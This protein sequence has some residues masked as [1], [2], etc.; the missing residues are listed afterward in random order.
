MRRGIIPKSSKP[1]P[2]TRI[3]PA[4][5]GVEKFMWSDMLRQ[6]RTGKGLTQHEM[7]ELMGISHPAYNRME[8]GRQ[9]PTISTLARVAE[10]LGLQLTVSLKQPGSKRT[11]PGMNF[12]V[13]PAEEQGLQA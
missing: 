11:K 5:K 2:K 3:R 9:I 13:T 1:D 7:A 10:A 8:S 4:M 12:T 6:A